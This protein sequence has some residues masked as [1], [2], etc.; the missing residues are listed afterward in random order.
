MPTASG[1]LLLDKVAIVTGGGAGIGGGI[2]RAFGAEGAKVAV[3]DVDPTRAVSTVEM[4]T[5]GGG[6][7]VAIEAD[8]R[9][10]DDVARIIE[11]SVN[12][13]G[14]VDILVNNVG[15]FL[16][17]GFD[18]ATS[19][20]EQWQELYETNL[21]HVLRMS[22]AVVPSMIEHGGGVII[23]LST[24][25]A[26]RAVPG[27]PVYG[28]FK[29]AAAH[30]MKSLAVG[31]AP[32]GIRCIDLA[33]DVTETPQLPYGQW[34][35]EDDQQKVP[36]WVPAGR[37]GTPDDFG[38]LAAFLA[39]DYA[40]FVTGVSIP[41]DGGTLAAGGWYRTRRPGRAWTNRPHEP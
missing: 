26:T 6:R 30:L 17:T 1:P 10:A 14:P 31:L 9:R 19:T 36:L 16:F 13:F 38:M 40:S 41:V 32:H 28:A 18:F 35:S 8:V 24:V 25:E 29:A 20:E 7:A 5:A 15:H 37:L 27:Q 12:T 21:L 11:I 4:I 33:P 39:S 22:R 34:L 2:S 3:V 23:G